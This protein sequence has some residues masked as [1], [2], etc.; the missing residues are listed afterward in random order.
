MTDREIMQKALEA[1]ELLSKAPTETAL[2]YADNAIDALRK[3]LAQP[4]P[5]SYAGI[6]IWI[7]DRQVVQHLT[8]TQLHHARDPW[9]L[10]E[11]T[12]GKCIAT[13]KENS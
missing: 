7:G 4:E 12:A 10:V 13:L 9:M 6:K 5:V 11:M 3:R 8:Q 2:D 1:L